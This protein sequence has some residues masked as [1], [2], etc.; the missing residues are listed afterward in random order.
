MLTSNSA[1]GRFWKHW[2]K[3]ITKCNISFMYNNQ[4]AKTIAIVS[5]KERWKGD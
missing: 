5:S 2:N 4:L 3:V 1:S